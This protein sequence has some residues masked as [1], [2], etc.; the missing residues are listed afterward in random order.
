MI[1]TQLLEH[2]EASSL[3]FRSPIHGLRHWHTVAR[4]GLYLA[5]FSGADVEV[6]RHFAYFHDCMRE[7]E[8]YDP[9]HGPRAAGFL[10]SIRPEIALDDNQF[11]LL[12][13]AC[14][15]HTH[16]KR[17]LC[18]T[19]GTCWDADRL[20]LGRVGIKPDSRYLFTDRAKEVADSEDF[21][22][23]KRFARSLQAK[24]ADMTSE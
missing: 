11:R 19:L 17:S 18:P 22:P 12:I 23:L 14:S 5:S 7:N 6:V 3:L 21:E 13:Q 1:A 16:A 2:L 20:D 24:I 10:K 9:G 4:N 8:S 15:G